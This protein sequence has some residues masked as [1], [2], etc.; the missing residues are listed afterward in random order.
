MQSQICEGLDQTSSTLF[1]SFYNTK[2][3][4]RTKSGNAFVMN[5]RSNGFSEEKRA[6]IYSLVWPHG[7]EKFWSAASRDLGEIRGH[8]IIPPHPGGRT[9]NFIK[10]CSSR[11]GR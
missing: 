4:A 1:V 7:Q 2:S 10:Y 9:I 11:V 6:G 3:V 5:C 8:K